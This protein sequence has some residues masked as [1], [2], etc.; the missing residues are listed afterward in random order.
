M[1]DLIPTEI[2]IKEY[3]DTFQLS[4]NSQIH[5]NRQKIL[6]EE[7]IH[8]LNNL[9]L[10]TAAISNWD[11]SYSLPINI[12]DHLAFLNK[13]NFLL[14]HI[15]QTHVFKKQNL[16]LPIITLSTGLTSPRNK[17]FGN[18]ILLGNNQ[19]PKFYAGLLEDVP[20]NLIQTKDFDWSFIFTAINFVSPQSQAKWIEF[21]S[22]FWR[23]YK[24]RLINFNSHLEQIS[25][26]NN[27]LW[28]KLWSLDYQDQSLPELNSVP[29]ELTCK[30]IILKHSQSIP[31]W[32][33]LF[34]T[35]SL[36]EILSLFRGVNTCW[37]ED[38][39]SGTHFFWFNDPDNK[40]NI[41]M[42]LEDGYLVPQYQEFTNFKIKWNKEIILENLKSGV[43]TPSVFISKAILVL[44]SGINIWSGFA[45][46]IYVNQMKQIW[47]KIFQ[48]YGYITEAKLLS[49]L[50]DGFLSAGFNL[51]LDQNQQPISAYDLI[52]NGGIS[53]K[54]LRDLENLKTDDIL[55]TNSK[56]FE[57]YWKN[58][59]N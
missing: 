3:L 31:Y 28:P 48:K 5:A 45:S 14:S 21:W 9:G 16:K 54:I 25:Y 53:Q 52:F 30:N 49:N 39:K 6:A 4:K 8:F 37:D 33:L 10:E 46:S 59:I 2:T 56:M 58:K 22:I 23:D 40:K 15:F 42:Y 57:D 51:L 17:L 50:G 7:I 26:F 32:D 18:R 24:S 1:S 43:I 36:E 11:F 13:Q 29:M 12:A 20:I 41:R 47:I 35:E 34:E 19:M 38:N 44:W 27:K 55:N